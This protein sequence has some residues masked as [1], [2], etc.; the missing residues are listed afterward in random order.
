MQT[1]RGLRAR[2]KPF[3]KGLDPVAERV[4]LFVCF[5]Y[6]LPRDQNVEDEI[7]AQ[8]E[9]IKGALRALRKLKRRLERLKADVKPIL[10]LDRWCDI[11]RATHISRHEPVLLP[12][13]GTGELASYLRRTHKAD[14]VESLDQFIKLWPAVLKLATR[15]IR[16]IQ[17]LLSNKASTRIRFHRRLWQHGAAEYVLKQL[18]AK[19]ST[20]KMLNKAIEERIAKIM[21]QLDSGGRT[22]DR[23]RGGCPAIREA[24]NRL[25]QSRQQRRRCDR[26][27]S[28]QMALTDPQ[29]HLSK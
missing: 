4:A 18:F 15:E 14:P 28:S 27:I 1:W 25:R 13:A 8:R 9:S 3:I 21:S 7:K 11:I 22:N 17:P 2:V 5:H 19:Y 10:E 20:R 12:L 6:Y 23:D 24:I 16:H 29:R 26:Y